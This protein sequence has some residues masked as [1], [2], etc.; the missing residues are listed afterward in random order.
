MRDGHIRVLQRREGVKQL[1]L[2]GILLFEAYQCKPF[3]SLSTLLLLAL[4]LLLSS[5]LA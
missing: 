2:A 5:L 1:A 3:L 4:L